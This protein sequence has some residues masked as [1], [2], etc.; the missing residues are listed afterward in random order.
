MLDVVCLRD[1]PESGR[2]PARTAFG[3]VMSLLSPPPREAGLTALGSLA[4]ASLV[5]PSPS[6]RCPSLSQRR[7]EEL[8]RSA[9]RAMPTVVGFQGGQDHRCIGRHRRPGG[10][11]APR[12]GPTE[13]G[14]LLPASLPGHAAPRHRPRSGSLQ[15][16]AS[17]RSRRVATTPRQARAPVSASAE[18]VVAR[19]PSEIVSTD[20]PGG[21]STSQTMMVSSLQQLLLRLPADAPPAAYK[22]AVMDE[23]V[24]G[25]ATTSG[26]E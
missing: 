15:A 26:R 24:L 4:P 5:A 14:L 7:P 21:P 9:L 20:A 13:H 10:S 16:L 3:Q 22:A 11:G 1:V 2:W 18:L 6:W 19:H 8:R 23:N 25:K 12:T 17:K